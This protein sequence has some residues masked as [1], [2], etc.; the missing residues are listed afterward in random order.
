L[1]EFNAGH[2]LN[3]LNEKKFNDCSIRNYSNFAEINTWIKKKFNE[4][5]IFFQR[6][7]GGER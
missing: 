6:S 4:R 1:H 2:L 7:K 3:A 5:E